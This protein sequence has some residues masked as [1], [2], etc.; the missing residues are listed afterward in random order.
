VRRVL[1]SF[2]PLALLCSYPQEI[3]Y[4]GTPL[5]VVL[6]TAAVLACS[7]AVVAWMWRRGLRSYSSASS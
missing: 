7:T 1:L 6:H 5:R 2:L 4:G 3:L